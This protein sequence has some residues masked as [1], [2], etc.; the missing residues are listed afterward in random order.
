M[1]AALRWGVAALTVAVLVVGIVLVL[2]GVIEAVGWLMETFGGWFG[3]LPT[4]TEAVI[5][6]P[7]GG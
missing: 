1:S 2:A 4:H 7:E 3:W 6:A 5:L